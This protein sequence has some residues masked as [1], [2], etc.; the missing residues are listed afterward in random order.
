MLQSDFLSHLYKNDTQLQRE[1]E[2]RQNEPLCISELSDCAKKVFAAKSKLR[3]VF[4]LKLRLSL[5]RIKRFL[6]VVG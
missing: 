2:V 1:Y 6:G 3:L 5:P 4:L